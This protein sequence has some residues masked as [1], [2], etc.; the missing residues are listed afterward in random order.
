[1]KSFRGKVKSNLKVDK[2]H[3]EIVLFWSID[4]KSSKL[5]DIRNELNLTQDGSFVIFKSSKILARSGG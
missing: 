1:M 3:I 4:A 5:L 2:F